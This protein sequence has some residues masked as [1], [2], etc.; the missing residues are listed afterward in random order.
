MPAAGRLGDC[1]G[2]RLDGIQRGN[3]LLL[4]RY[5]NEA[6]ALL[7]GDLKVVSQQ[8]GHLQRGAALIGLDLEYSRYR[9]AYPPG[10]LL[11]RD[12]QPFSPSSDPLTE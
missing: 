9:A 11:L 8:L 10:K 2:K 4:A 7:R 1:L 12:V 5:F 6:G 3:G